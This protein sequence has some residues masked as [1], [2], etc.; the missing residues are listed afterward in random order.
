MVHGFSRECQPGRCAGILRLGKAPARLAVLK[1]PLSKFAQKLRGTDPLLK[2]W[3][4]GLAEGTTWKD[5][6]RH[7]ASVSN[8]TCTDIMKG[9]IAV[10]A[11]GS[12]KDVETAVASLNGSEL[13]GAE[14]ASVWHCLMRRTCGSVTVLGF[15][16]TDADKSLM[17]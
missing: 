14:V 2:V 16:R 3:V 7:C 6:D 4:G 12:V 17:L 10:V 1:K 9:G 13:K 8:P 11:Y 15:S 5:V